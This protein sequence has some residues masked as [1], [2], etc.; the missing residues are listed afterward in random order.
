MS[1]AEILLYVVVIG[2]IAYRLW[3]VFG[4][5]NGDENKPRAVEISEFAEK[6]KMERGKSTGK[7][8]MLDAKPLEVKE[9]EVPTHLKSDVAAAR[10]IDPAFL[11]SKFIEGAGSAFEMVIKAFSEGKK[12][13]LKFL[14]SPDVYNNF[15][16]EI[17]ERKRTETTAVH[18]IYS[19]QD[20]EVL[21]IEVK[22]NIC[23]VVVR[24]VSEQFNY[25]R[26]KAGE[27]THGS[28][29][30]LDHVTDVWTF[31]RDL[32]S[33]KPNWVVVGIQSA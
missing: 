24:F 18:S 30:E 3:T 13:A 21:D 2:I 5:T 27:I 22:D 1:D 15:E 16:K 19:M 4:R 10:K 28:K 20:P 17:D 12:D 23:Q 25:I 9:E 6:I 32:T 26:S 8:I 14:L 33:K 11:L 7:P 31:E 29:T